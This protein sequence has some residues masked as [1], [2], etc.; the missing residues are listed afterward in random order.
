MV[1]SILLL[2]SFLPFV[3]ISNLWNT[4]PKFETQTSI[5][6]VKNSDNEFLVNISLDEIKNADYIKLEHTL[7]DNFQIEAKQQDGVKVLKSGN[8]IKFEI[9]KNISSISY[10]LTSNNATNSFND[11]SISRKLYVLKNNIKTI[12]AEK[13]VS[14][15][16]AVKTKKKQDLSQMK[17]ERNISVSSENSREY[18]VSLKLSQYLGIEGFAKI[19]DAIPDGFTA[20]PIATQEGIFSFIDNQAKFLWLELP[21]GADINVSYKLKA[22]DD[23]KGD[24]FIT[25]TFTYILN[26]ET[27]KLNIEKSKITLKE[28]QASAVV[29][30][31]T[32]TESVAKV[33]EKAVATPPAKSNEKPTEISKAVDNKTTEKTEVAKA[34]ESAKPSEKPKATT[35]TKPQNTAKTIETKTEKAKTEPTETASNQKAKPSV[36]N[37]ASNVSIPN[38]VSGVN[39]RVQIAAGKK[40]ISNFQSYFNQKYN[41]NQQVD[42]EL[43]DGWSKYI[44]GNFEMYEK[45]RNHREDLISNHK[46]ETGPFVSAYNNGKRI[47]VQEALM[48]TNQKWIQ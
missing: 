35:P 6:K 22:N 38:P 20:S 19:T 29:T 1:K 23:L 32:P 10:K 7:S 25:G 12:I 46:V 24:F 41:F 45:A 9:K 18:I 33:E 3:F 30:T 8:K 44:T 28:G 5:E 36:K 15:T 4:S 21:N 14:N 13:T 31:P 11:I 48:I 39:Y 17:C 34:T 43:H 27:K 40:T 42:V 47:T 37:N 16:K 26:K 2:A